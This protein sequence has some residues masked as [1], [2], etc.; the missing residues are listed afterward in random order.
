[1]PRIFKLSPLSEL[2]E[3]FFHSLARPVPQ[4]PELAG[5]HA[6]LHRLLPEDPHEETDRPHQD[7]EEQ[8]QEYEGPKDHDLL[9]D[10]LPSFPERLEEGDDSMPE[11]L[12]HAHL[13]RIGSQDDEYRIRRDPIAHL[14]EE[15]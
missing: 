15:R 3:T 6:P 5:P 11:C 1:M 9:G 2:S 8:E 13:H 7:D 12:F 4:S 14:C 10:L